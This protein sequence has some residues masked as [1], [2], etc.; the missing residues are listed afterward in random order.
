MKD[1]DSKNIGNEFGKFFA[2]LGKSYAAKIDPSNVKISDYISKIPKQSKSLFLTPCTVVEIS[3]IIANLPTK[4]SSGFDN[5]SNKLLKQIQTSISPH[6]CTI[7]NISLTTGIFPDIMKHAEVIPLYKGGE[8]CFVVNYRPISLL[9]TISKIL[10]K[11]IY[12]RTYDFLNGN[13][14]LYR[15]QYGFRKKHSCD[16]AVI[17]LISNIVKSMEKGEYTIAIF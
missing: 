11:V 5:I 15:S 13:G 6:L 4:N 17:E 12:K 7:F 10:E 8:K 3:K 14:S 9:M 16:H 1:Y 2:T